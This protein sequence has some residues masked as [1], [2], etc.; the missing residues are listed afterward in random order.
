MGEVYLAQDS[1]LGRQ[2][3]LKIL[4]P[5]LVRS[6]E[7][8][9]RF[10]QEAKSASSLNHPNIV[11]IYEIGEDQVRSAS[12]EL[13][14][15]SGPVQYISMELVAGKTLGAKIYEERTDLRTLLGHLAQAAEGIAKA[16]AAGIVHRDLKPG[17]I[18]VSDDGFAKVLDFGLAKLTEKQGP[19]VELSNAPTEAADRTLGGVVLGTAGYMS[20]EQ[21]LGKT[22][23]PRSDIFS[24]GCILYEATTRGRPFVADSAVETMHKILHDKPRPVEELNPQAPAELRRLI[25]KCLAKNPDQRMQSM[26]DLALDLREIVDEFE[27]LSA[28]TSSGSSAGSGSAVALQPAPRRSSRAWMA[29][30]AGVG[31]IGVLG[32]AFG[33]YGMRSG[34]EAGQGGEATGPALAMAGITSRGDISS[35]AL[36]PDGR[37]MAYVSDA[38]GQST[39]LVRQIST[40]SEVKILSRP[41]GL[42]V[43]AY[44]PSGEHLFFWEFDPKVN[45][46]SLH[47]VPALGGTPRK[48]VAVLHSLIGFAPDGKRICFIRQSESKGEAAIVIH[49]QESGEEKTLL[50]VKLPLSFEGNPAWSPDGKTIAAAVH[51]PESGVHAKLVA[52][53][54]DDGKQAPFGATGW[55]VRSLQW[56]PDGRSLLVSAYKYGA[57]VSDQIWSVA[58]P[59]G[60]SRRVTT[61]NNDYDFVSL[62]RDASLLA[63][64]RHSRVANLWTVPLAAK[65]RPRQLTFN[66]SSESSVGGFDLADNASIVF[67][68]AVENHT[69]VFAVGADGEGLRQLTSGDAD[70]NVFRALPGGGF[71]GSTYAADRVAHIFRADG[72]GGNVRRVTSLS[73][74][75]F[76]NL[77][78]D[79]KTVLFVRAESQRDLWS[80][81]VEGGEPRKI[82]TNAYEVVGFSPDGTKIAFATPPE[83]E[84]R[85]ARTVLVIPSTGGEPVARLTLPADS[86]HY[87]WMPD[88]SALAY[89]AGGSVS[90]LFRQPLGGEAAQPITR[91]VEGQ[92]WAQEWT[93]DG[94]TVLLNRR[95]GDVSNLWAVTTDGRD[96]VALTDFVTG[97][98]FDVRPAADGKTIVFTYGSEPRDAVLVRN[99]R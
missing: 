4:P 30:V 26:K 14:G 81:A 65:S 58:Y 75:W 12:G 77:S 86:N 70:E 52:I 21:A 19:G 7:R 2:V 17:N 8:V 3:A 6:Q 64:T 41:Q 90:N 88:G 78:A 15:T 42:G 34:R 74:E 33:I 87:K 29:A 71:V 32:I 56:L 27:T 35:V 89:F 97:S 23:D 59:G 99:F 60:E 96:P 73:G 47:Q 48:V 38:G 62:S 91:F 43:M 83:I 85:S 54:V 69:H 22:V 9:R 1:T 25:R 95:V 5:E 61:D 11:T 40:G 18:M 39:L 36:A 68:Q 72:D 44:S 16:H 93:R 51:T 46:A 55:E 94:K 63:V 92:L 53:A 76:Q 80:V 50:T 10:V 49:D 84:G 31:V 24:F 20:P 98:I 82:A 57:S 66:T 79:G 28:S 13:G 45:V 37:Y 67:S